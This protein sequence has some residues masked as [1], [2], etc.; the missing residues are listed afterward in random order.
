MPDNYGYTPNYPN[1][2]IGGSAQSN[3]YGRIWTY[4]YWSKPGF[5]QNHPQGDQNLARPPYDNNG[6]LNWGGSNN[7]GSGNN[8]LN[9]NN[10][11]RNKRSPVTARPP[12]GGH[13]I[14][15]QITPP[16]MGDIIDIE[17]RIQPCNG[18]KFDLKVVSPR[19]AVLGEVKNLR[20]AKMSEM[21]DFRPP[22]LSRVF[23]V[24]SSSGQITLNPSSGIPASCVGDFLHAV[25]NHLAKMKTNVQF[26]MNQ[27]SRANHDSYQ[28]AMKLNNHKM[29][30][31]G[32]LGC[33]CQSTFLRIN[34]TSKS[35]YQDLMGI[36]H[37]EG[38]FEVRH[39]VTF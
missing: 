31:L 13:D 6:N 34:G 25:D 12:H 2:P 16:F 9:W 20:L 18:Y 38:M 8:G 23:R 14:H 5:E 35:A 29:E 28:W 11:R 1:C 7:G 19:N 22:P 3:Q 21:Q 26:H 30:Q 17:F 36:Y 27:E 39:K 15:Q 33:A 4:C 24:D 10:Q 37:F 32:A